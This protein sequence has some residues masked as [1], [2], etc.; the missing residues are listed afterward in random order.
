LV[1]M[2]EGNIG[3]CCTTQLDKAKILRDRMIRLFANLIWVFL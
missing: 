2:G 3:G 1:F